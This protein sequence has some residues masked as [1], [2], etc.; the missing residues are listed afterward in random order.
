MGF[1]W[2]SIFGFS[3]SPLELFVRGTIIYWFIF[4]L[5]RLAGRRDFGAIGASDVLVMVLIADAAQNGMAAEY[6]TTLEGMVLI[7]TIVFWSVFIDRLCYWVPAAR[8]ILEPQRVCL[9]KDGQ[10]QR[11]G[12]RREHI[13]H[14][15][16]MGELRLKGVDDIKKV[17]RAYM[18]DAGDISV[19]LYQKDGQA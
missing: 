12:M 2:D 18:E 6:K 11:R 10:I 1:E 15:E 9:I 13:T 14:E 3:M 5:L 7:A 16:L 4:A 19:L 17:R 8:N